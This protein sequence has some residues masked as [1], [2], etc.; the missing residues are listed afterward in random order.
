MS[1]EDLETCAAVRTLCACNQLRRTARA[2]TQHY[3]RALAPSGLKAT[4]LPILVALGE[5]R[6]V[7]I[8]PLAG[9]LALDRTTLTRNLRVLE[10]RGLVTMATDA[11]DARVHLVT[12]TD[13]GARVLGDALTIWRELQREVEEAFAGPRLE[14]L[15]A[16]LSTLAATLS[17]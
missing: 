9:G 11:G 10:Q 6:P 3:E 7:P 5:G 17:R 16:E 4:Q 15:F 2:M 8:T 14:A 12:L 13:D 1:A